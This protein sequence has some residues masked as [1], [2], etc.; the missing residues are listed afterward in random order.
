MH[1]I[2][3]LIA[4]LMLVPTN[5]TAQTASD[6]GPLPLEELVRQ[7]K[8]ALLQVAESREK[9]PKL[10]NAM[11]VAKTSVQLKGDGKIS[12]WVVELG[13]GQNNEYATT[14]TLT[15]KPPPPGSPSN[16]RAVN[17]ADTLREAILSGARAVAEAGKGNPPLIADKL[18]A[19]V[20]FAV[21][22]D[23]NGRLAIKF[24]PFG[25]SGGGGVTSGAVQTIV[26][27]YKR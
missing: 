7:L 13:G 10:D 11:L 12:L 19:S 20:H 1:R 16:V 15:L 6:S 3:W 18:E 8:V 23:A 27:T 4:F 17:L 26:V 5:G 22:R 25:A 24:P 21:Q 14:V 9:L 2:I